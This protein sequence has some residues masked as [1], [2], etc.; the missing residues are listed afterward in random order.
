M[1][2]WERV[3]NVER[4]RRSVNRLA[5]MD[6]RYLKYFMDIESAQAQREILNHWTTAP[7]IFV[8]AATAKL[9]SSSSREK[10]TES[11]SSSG[12]TWR[13]DERPTSGEVESGL[14]SGRRALRKLR[15]CFGIE[16]QAEEDQD[17]F[18]PTRIA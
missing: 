6:I 2:S 16:S 14:R 3:Y 15:G 10:S 9:P 8:E 4:Y 12:S 5:R 18:Y 17:S 1:S 7:L 13:Y 11:K